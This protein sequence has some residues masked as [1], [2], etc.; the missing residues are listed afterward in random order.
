MGFRQKLKNI[1]WLYNIMLSLL[2]NTDYFNRR[3]NS[4]FPKYKVSPY[5]RARIDK[6]KQSTDNNRID[7]VTDSGKVF[8]NYQLMHNGIRITLGSYYD[9]GN[10][11]LLIENKGVHEPQEEYIFQQVLPFIREGGTM[12]EL[13]SYWAFYSLWFASKVKNAKC[14]M[15]EP[16][17]HKMNF[18]KLNFRLNALK[19]QFRLGFI[20]GST[21]TSK[22]IPTYDVDHLMKEFE[23]DFL[24][25]LH[26]D[27]QGYELKMLKGAADALANQKV[28][29]AFI[30]THSNELH[31]QCIDELKKYGYVIVADAN[32]D[33]SYAT[34]GVIVARGK[35]VK[36]PEVIEISKA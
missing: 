19:G 1:P 8:P 6:V 25:I 12:M 15:I 5:W 3:F 34:D 35:G 13:G 11:Q 4:A 17:P 2:N 30:S 22:S 14:I 23:I 32:L 26:S 36:G 28:G 33:E 21:D 7:H 20:D 24:D 9:Y 16:D 31:Q 10:T 29:Y 18:G 27:I